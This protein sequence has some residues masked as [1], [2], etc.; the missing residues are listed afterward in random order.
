VILPP[1]VFPGQSY[2]EIT[3]RLFGPSFNFKTGCIAAM[4][5]CMVASKVENSAQVLI[6]QSSEAL[7]KG[8][9]QYCWHPQ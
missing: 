3:K 6:V 7:L 4:H 5:T 2:K 8:E 9:A 1:L